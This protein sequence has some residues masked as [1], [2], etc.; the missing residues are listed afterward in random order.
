LTEVDIAVSLKMRLGLGLKEKKR[1]FPLSE[2]GGTLLN[3][4]VVDTL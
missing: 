1:G 3:E 2:A 4:T